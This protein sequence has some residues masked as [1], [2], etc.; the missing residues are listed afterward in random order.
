MAVRVLGWVMREWIHGGNHTS[1][2]ALVN[3]KLRIDKDCGL[4]QGGR[5]IRVSHLSDRQ[6]LRTRPE[7]AEELAAL[8][9]DWTR[10]FG[11]MGF[12]AIMRH[13]GAQR[14]TV[15]KAAA[16][17][18]IS[19]TGEGNRTAGRRTAAHAVP[20]AAFAKQPDYIIAQVFGLPRRWVAHQRKAR[21]LPPF[22]PVRRYKWA[23][24]DWTRRTSDIAQEMGVLEVCVSRARRRFAPSTTC[25]K[26]HA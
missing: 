7:D 18:G 17:L 9:A 15:H 6:Y 22:K 21:N 16:C 25:R 5:M 4:V 19:N 11:S 10:R 3:P 12:S 13:T 14:A 26:N 8:R 1:C 23:D 20:D 24:V 2:S